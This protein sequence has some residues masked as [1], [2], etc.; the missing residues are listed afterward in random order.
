MKTVFTNETIIDAYLSQKQDSGRT[1]NDA[2]YFKGVTL[3]SYGS[4]FPLC[5]LDESRKVAICNSA[6]YSV[7]TSK[8]QSMIHRAVIEKGYHVIYVDGLKFA[9]TSIAPSDF[10][11]TERKMWITKRVDSNLCSFFNLYLY[12]KDMKR[13]GTKAHIQLMDRMNDLKLNTFLLISKY[14]YDALSIVNEM[15]ENYNYFSSESM[16]AINLIRADLKQAS[17]SQN[18]ETFVNETV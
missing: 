4:H 14:G 7:T 2:M 1:V 17:F 8:Q 10:K 15:Q 18:Y 16:I 9:G 13:K 12:E 3:Y 11:D 6:S 5:I